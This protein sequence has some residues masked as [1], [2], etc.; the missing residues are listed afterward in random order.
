MRSVCFALI[1]AVSCGSDDKAIFD[2]GDGGVGDGNSVKYDS[3]AIEP[4]NAVLNVALSGPPTTQNYKAIATIG[5]ATM[6]VTQSCGWNVLD[7]TFGAFT[8][9][10]FTAQPRGGTTQVNASCGGAIGT[11]NVTLKLTGFVNQGMAPANSDTLF[12]NAQLG[13]DPMRTPLV[14][15][16]LD[17]AV[18]PLNI[19]PIDSQW[20]TAQN[21]LFH[22]RFTSTNIALSIYTTKA[23]A[24]F[25][26]GTWSIVAESTSGDT[27]AIDVEGLLQNNPATKYASKPVNLRMS[28]D[29]IENTAI[30]YWAS[31]NG[32]LMTQTFGQTTA[33][34]VVHGD[35]TSC[36]SVS[37]AGSRIGYSRCVNGDCGQVFAGFMR[38][39]TMNKVWKDTLDANTK[40]VRGSYTTFAPVGYPFA[41]DKQS[42]ALLA[43]SDCTLGTWNP[44]TGMPAASNSKA[45]SPHP[46]N[47]CATMP[48]WSPDGKKI[49]FASSPNQ[50]QFVDVS[51]SALA[52][53]T[54]AYMNSMHSFGEPQLI[55]ST[56]ITLSSGTYNNF[57]F[58]SYTPDGAFVVFNAARSGW[59]NFSNAPSAG[60]RLMM[61]TPTGS[62]TV[63]LASLNG[64]GD[65]DITWPHWAPTKAVDYYWVVFSS[66]RDYGHLLTT[67]NSAAKC[68]A[69]GVQHCKQIW[70]GA[71]DKSV[72]MKANGSMPPPDPSA[73]PVWMPG[74]EINA[75]NISPYWTLPTSSIP[76]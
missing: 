22:V 56:P 67:A 42:V 68:I 20:T 9:A 4:A 76:N 73:P 66:E 10:V 36:H 24:M 18:A 57:F 5:G 74:Q 60:Q 11:T 6:D 71:V 30:Y 37:R 21:D 26:A 1:L 28:K 7:A 75:D 61:T 52:T 70:I 25:D 32:N 43:E 48:D 23:D 34:N 14:E 46:G 55:L 27:I 44:D 15:Y 19:P 62:W 39:D 35:C 29:T 38:Y 17:T 50:G 59:R 45:V 3:I 41:D 12:K 54:Y 16:P 40:T 2:A 31:S 69:N 47:R 72:L 65:L 51:N 13:A 8:G 33:P 49:I 63:D 53:M 64:P 58:P